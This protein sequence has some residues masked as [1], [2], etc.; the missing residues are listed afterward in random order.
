MENY[1]NYFTEIEEH[2]QKRRGQARP[3]SPL[4]WSLIESLR[5][6]GVPLEVVLRG[7]DRA[8]DRR[9]KRQKV[10]GKVNSLAYCTQNILAEHERRKESRVGRND[11]ATPAAEGDLEVSQ[12][13]ELLESAGR[14]L[15][16][17]LGG[18][19]AAELPA[20]IPVVERVVG[21]LSGIILEIQASRPLDY[22]ALEL[23]L[24]TLEE[25]ILATIFSGMDEESLLDVKKETQ[26]EIHRHKRG[27]KSEHIAMLES[28][29]TRKKLLQAFGVPRLSLFYLSLN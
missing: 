24:N 19:K 16:A 20:L 27:L 15:E 28:K 1:F 26:Q 10:V 4:D 7:V 12:L 17:L 5:E 11:P 3:L 18:P 2:F 6:A 22:E 8:F 25:R 14:Q 13:L 29:L 9:T 23:K 21:S